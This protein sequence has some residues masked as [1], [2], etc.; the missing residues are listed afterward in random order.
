MGKYKKIGSQ[1]HLVLTNYSCCFFFQLW[2][3]EVDTEAV[4][5]AADPASVAERAVAVARRAAAVAG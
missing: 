3:A 5:D 2:R 1:R 4:D